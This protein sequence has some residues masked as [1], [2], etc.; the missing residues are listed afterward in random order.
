M[1]KYW[2][3]LCFF[4]FLIKMLIVRPN[5][6][7]AAIVLGFLTFYGYDK[8]LKHKQVPEINKQFQ[9]ELERVKDKVGQIALTNV[10]KR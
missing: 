3:E 1:F 6:A 9:E 4:L 2:K 10:Y 7:E 8:Y 5:V